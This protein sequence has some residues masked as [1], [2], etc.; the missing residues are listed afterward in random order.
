MNCFVYT[1]GT[2]GDYISNKTFHESI[3]YKIVLNFK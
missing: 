1:L 2:I 3:E